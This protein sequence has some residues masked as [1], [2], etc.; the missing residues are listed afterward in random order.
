MC[1]FQ[2]EMTVDENNFFHCVKSLC[3]AVLY[4]SVGGDERLTLSKSET[5]FPHLPIFDS[6]INNQFLVL[7]QESYWLPS[8]TSPVRRL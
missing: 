3:F 7:E 4:S 1:L 6:A 8:D 2:R 5:S